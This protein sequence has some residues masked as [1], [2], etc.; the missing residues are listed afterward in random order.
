M[1]SENQFCSL[2]VWELLCLTPWVFW[3]KIFTRHSSLCLLSFR[4]DLTWNLSSFVPNSSEVL[5]WNF[6]K[7][8]FRDNFSEI[9]CK[10]KAILYRNLWNSAIV[11]DIF[12]WV[13]IALKKF[14]QVLSCVV[15]GQVRRHVHK[16]ITKR[17]YG[18]ENLG[19][20]VFGKPVLFT[21]GLKFLPDIPHCVYG[22][23]AK[24]WAP[25][26]SHKIGDKFFI[27][28]CQ[29]RKDESFVCETVWFFS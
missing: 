3:S 29:G 18:V 13:R 27:H 17:T 26:S 6:R 15:F 16:K 14:T 2:W 5:T 22:V 12:F 10:T 28:H 1:F 23:L 8:L 11:S 7:K 24:I 9:L 4:V 19:R 25:D 21:L 20:F